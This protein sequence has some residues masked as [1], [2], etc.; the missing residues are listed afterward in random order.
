[1]LSLGPPTFYSYKMR[2][3]IFGLSLLKY[4]MGKVWNN[5]KKK[6]LHANLHSKIMNASL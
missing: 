1:M 2:E 5:M 4:C 3:K 6:G